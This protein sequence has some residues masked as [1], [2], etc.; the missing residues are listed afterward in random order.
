M[1][2]TMCRPAAAEEQR[3]NNLVREPA[4]QEEQ[5]AAAAATGAPANPGSA[6]ELPRQKKRKLADGEVNSMPGSSPATARQPLPT[7][8]APLPHAGTR[9][10]AIYLQC[11]QLCISAGTSIRLGR[12]RCVP[13]TDRT[14]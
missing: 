4:R 10:A 3:A 13:M 1:L 6:A 7:P 5:Q 11:T 8:V 9:H 12:T 14:G 2:C